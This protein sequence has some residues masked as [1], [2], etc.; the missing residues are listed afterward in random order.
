MTF[1]FH[2]SVVEAVRQAAAQD[3]ETV[4]FEQMWRSRHTI[5]DQALSAARKLHPDKKLA[6]AARAATIKAT[7]AR[8]SPGGC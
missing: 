8:N 5:A 6:K 3:P 1:A 7:S 2:T 4:L